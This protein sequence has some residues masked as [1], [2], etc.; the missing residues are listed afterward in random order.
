MVLYLKEG[1]TDAVMSF[2]EKLSYYRKK[3]ALSARE[4][5]KLVGVSAIAVKGF[6][7]NIFKPWQPETYDIKV[8]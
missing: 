4:I 8:N 2:G 7:K 5:G 6:E 1:K 3:K